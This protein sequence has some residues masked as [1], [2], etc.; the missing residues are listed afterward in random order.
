MHY[1]IKTNGHEYEVH[2]RK[3]EGHTAHITVND[4]DYDVE[5]EG[6]IVNPTRMGSKPLPRPVQTGAP[7]VVKPAVPKTNP[8]GVR[9]PLPGVLLDICVKEG[10]EVK[11]GQELYVLEAMKMEN[12]I[13]ADRSGVVEKIYY[14]KG[15]TVLEGDVILDI[16]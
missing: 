8:M 1:K 13:Q 10:D 11:T 9:T 7:V 15:D 5:V 6:L 12:S 16:K 2:I 4:I 14:A 3:V